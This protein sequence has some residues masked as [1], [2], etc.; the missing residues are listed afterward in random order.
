M[1]HKRFGS[2]FWVFI[3]QA[4][5]LQSAYGGTSDHELLARETKNVIRGIEAQTGLSVEVY[6]SGTDSKVANPHITF[7]G[8]NKNTLGFLR[9]YVSILQE[10]MKKYTPAFLKQFKISRILLVVNLKVKGTRRIACPVFSEGNGT[11]LLDYHY[12]SYKKTKKHQIYARRTIHHEI[13]HFI[14]Y[15]HQS[16]KW[17]NDD[18]LWRGWNPP[19]FHYGNGGE[20]MYDRSQGQKNPAALNHPHEG[21]I[22]LYA[23]SAVW[24]DKAEIFSTLFVNEAREKINRFANPKWR[25]CES[26]HTNWRKRCDTYLLN[27]IKHMVRWLCQYGGPKMIK[28]RSCA[29]AG[30]SAST[31]SSKP[32]TMEP[33]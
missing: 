12:G 5:F 21:F 18:V 30:W 17:R 24:E 10:E 32:T 13:F 6:I 9:D 26:T 7:R 1:R 15:N 29:V 20:E 25:I 23:T 19:G 11:L 31:S 14:D 2:V 4:L 3:F 27:K 8:A 28:Q 22:S 16:K 33:R